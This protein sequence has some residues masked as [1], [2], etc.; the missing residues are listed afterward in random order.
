MEKYLPC[1][2][3]KIPVLVKPKSSHAVCM[4]RCFHWARRLSS[5]PITTNERIALVKWIITLPQHC[6]ICRSKNRLT[7]DRIVPGSKGGKYEKSNLQILCYKCNC[8]LK[9][10]YE[11]I[12]EARKDHKE[13]SCRICKKVK[14][15]TREYFHRTGFRKMTIRKVSK[16]QFHGTCKVCRSEISKK[17][18]NIICVYCKEKKY[19][20]IKNG[21]YCSIKCHYA[22]RMRIHSKIINCLYCGK[23]YKEKKSSKRKYCSNKCSANYWKKHKIGIYA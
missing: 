7:L 12:N 11:S 22:D 5:K 8:T 6:N 19:S 3:C 21:K 23:E 10:N 20:S 4:K 9:I 13:K 14:P 17:R 1:Y 15:L 2:Y 16:S 18:F